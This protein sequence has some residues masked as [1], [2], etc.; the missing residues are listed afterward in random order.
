MTLMIHDVV[1]L[2]DAVLHGLVDPGLDEGLVRRGLDVHGA[3]QSR[4]FHSCNDTECG[5]NSYLPKCFL[6]KMHYLD[7]LLLLYFDR[8]DK[9]RFKNKRQLLQGNYFICVGQFRFAIYFLS[10]LF[11]D[12]IR[13]FFNGIKRFL[14][15]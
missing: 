14:H 8:F 7:I 1:V 11:S 5:L 4:D 6:I 10:L 15:M 2:G 13:V 12:I 3:N 9:L